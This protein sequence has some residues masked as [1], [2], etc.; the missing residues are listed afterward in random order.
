MQKWA[1]YIPRIFFFLHLMQPAAESPSKR[2]SPVICTKE[3]GNPT[4]FQCPVWG[5]LILPASSKKKGMQAKP[6]LGQ[7]QLHQGEW[8]EHKQS[9]GVLHTLLAVIPTGGHTGTAA[10]H[11][12]SSPGQPPEHCALQTPHR[13]TAHSFFLKTLG[14]WE[15]LLHPLPYAGLTNHVPCGKVPFHLLSW[16]CLLSFIISPVSYPIVNAEWLNISWGSWGEVFA[17]YSSTESPQLFR[18]GY[19]SPGGR[20]ELTMCLFS[21]IMSPVLTK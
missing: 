12:P 9:P 19:L 11:V 16:L 4:A 7:Q 1:R 8:T 21:I 14:C 18:L 2:V 13:P 17:L 3:G 10:L 20:A 5:V 15:Q 6:L